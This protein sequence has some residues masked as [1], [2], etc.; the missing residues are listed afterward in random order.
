MRLAALKRLGLAFQQDFS[1]LIIGEEM[2]ENVPAGWYPT[3]DGK[4]RYWDGSQWTNLPWDENAEAV[5]ST[6]TTSD[7][8]PPV[9]RNRKRLI[10][11]GLIV[12]IVVG[13]VAG[14]LVWKST[15]D[16]QAKEAA[17]LAQ[18]SHAKK[19][20]ADKAAAKKAKDDAERASRTL[21]VDEIQTSVKTMAKKHASEGVIDGPI[22]SVSCSPVN[23]G[24]TDDLTQQTTVFECFVADKNNSDGTQSGYFYNATMNWTSGSYTYGLGKPGN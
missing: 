22:L 16:A 4:Q 18:I 6:S 12:V 17:A 19:V 8:L 23:G 9:K 24:S 1:F 7:A 20:A 14:A 5:T 15:T 21:E 11:I 3:P 2:A 13:L 10:A